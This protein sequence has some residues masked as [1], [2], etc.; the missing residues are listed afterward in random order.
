MMSIVMGQAGDP[1]IDPLALL[2]MHRLRHTVF[3]ER[4]Q[5]D[6]RARDGMEI[7]D[8][9]DIDPTYMIAKSTGGK[10]EGCWRLLSTIGP[11]MLKDTFPQL[12]R[13]EPAP[14]HPRI[15]EL[16]R[17]AVAPAATDD[18]RQVNLGPV[19]FRMLERA[20]DYAMANGIDSYVTATSV[21]LER[22]MRRVGVPLRRFGDGKAVRIGRVLSVACWIDVTEEGRTAVFGGATRMLESVA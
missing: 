9:D 13:G 2:G 1:S 7:D 20:C 15:W 22:L 12:L 19:T 3:S 16:S 14:C 18:R 21:A 6:V 10:V 5:W 4:L 11:Y 17:F 8:F